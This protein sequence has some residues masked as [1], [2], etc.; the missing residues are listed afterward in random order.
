VRSNL[1]KWWAS[2]TF[3]TTRPGA[4]LS[5]LAVCG[6]IAGLGESLIAIL[7]VGLVS[8]DRGSHL[9]STADLSGSWAIAALIFAVLIV[10]AAAHALSAWVA[11]RA[12]VDVQ[13]E[14]Q[15]RITVAYLDAPWSARAEERTGELQ[16]LVSVRAQILA[17]G[18]QE[19]AKGLTSALN[20]VT[21]VIAAVAL[22]LAATAGLLLAM[23]AVVA[24]SVMLQGRRRQAV[25]ES[26]RAQA[27]LAVELTEMGQL[28]RELH[29]F[30]VEDAARRELTARIAEAARLQ[31][32]V[33]LGRGLSPVL[34]RDL[35]VA[36]IVVALAAVVVTDGTGASSLGAA[37]VLVLR[38]LSHAR[39]LVTLGD[40]WT[41]RQESSARIQAQIE[42]WRM[43]G[44]RGTRR[45]ARV[46]EIALDDVSFTYPGATGPALHGVGLRLRR[47]D[48]VGVIGRTGSGKSTLA[49]ILLGLLAP[50]AGRIT[51]DG[52]PLGELDRQDWHAR[53]AWVSQEPRLLTGTVAENVRFL[54]D[55][56]DDAAIDRA[57]AAV[58]LTA[59]LEPGQAVGPAGASISGGQRQRI[60][61]ARALAG[62]PDVIVLD[63][64]TSAL[65][66]HAEEVIHLALDQLGAQPIV[67][68]IAHRL[69][70]IRICARVIALDAGG[71]RT[72]E[73]P[74]QIERRGAAWLSAALGSRRLNAAP[75]PVGDLASSAVDDVSRRSSR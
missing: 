11:A 53:T 61:L 70:T 37:L 64:P 52:V 23:V 57:V 60:A 51:V 22:S 63:E 75:R 29:V 1:L 73:A 19:A 65:D 34:I 49:G 26:A 72:V 18:T 40:R 68:A 35:T 45:C 54:R 59:E 28:T 2:A 36:F 39:S 9:L 31:G 3:G 46:G 50:T 4:R 17:E 66:V 69:S 7:V 43:P 27:A 58:G 10:L 12:A 42:A 30:G 71:V 55:P 8:G 44:A 33:R 56:I 16:E 13:R 21:V 48:V 62:D 15:T 14:V 67:V 5:V 32:R 41:E 20:L 6:V 74:A 25:R 24:I 47:G 38:A